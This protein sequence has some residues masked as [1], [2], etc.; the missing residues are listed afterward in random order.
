MSTLLKASHLWDGYPAVRH[1]LW[2]QE[3]GL[4]QTAS[5]YGRKLATPWMVQVNGRWRRVYCCCFSNIGTCFI[6]KS[7]NRGT[8]LHSDV[9]VPLEEA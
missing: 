8:V 3:R 6:G 7:L 1:P 2:W 4:Q 9:L 5:G